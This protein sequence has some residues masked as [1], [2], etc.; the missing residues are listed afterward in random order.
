MSARFNTCLCGIS[1]VAAGLIA[2]AAGPAVGEEPLLKDPSPTL[3]TDNR[4]ADEARQLLK[5][6]AAGRPGAPAKRSPAGKF[7]TTLDP[8]LID[9]DSTPT[10]SSKL[11]VEKSSSDVKVGKDEKPDSLTPIPEAGNAGPVEIE[12]TSFHGV[13]PGVS[14]QEEVEKAWGKP[15]EV[16]KQDGL[17]MYLFSVKPFSHIE[18]NYLANKV[19]SVIIRFEHGFPS[20]TVAQQ[21]DLLKVQPVL[22]SNELGEILGQSYP[23]RGVLFSFEPGP[24]PSKTLKRVT[25]IILEPIT[26]DPFILRAE[27]NLDN[28][29]EF[30]LHDL[31]AA[32]KLQPANARSHWLRS[33]VLTLLGQHEKAMA[34][35]GEAVRLDPKEA[36]YMV[37]RALTMAQAGHVVEAIPE[38]QKAV[39]LG[40]SR[41]HVK[42][43]ALCLL[44]DLT[45]STAPPDFKLAF[46]YHMQAIQVADPLTTSRH[47][48][49]R[50]AAKELLVD[51]HLG[52][53]HDIAWGEWREKE[54]AVENWI[55]KASVLADDL[56]KNEGTGPEH[57]FRIGTR[58]L[59]ACV[60]IQGR[61]DPAFWTSETIRAGDNLIAATPD[62][63]RKSQLQWE[64]AMS[65]YDAL[66]VYQ[67]RSDRQS[68]LKYGELAISYLE[69][70]GRQNQSATTSYLLG[71]LYFRMGAVYAV[72]EGNHL[73]AVKWFDKAVPL[74]GKSPP[75]D[76]QAS[77]GRLGETFVSMGVSYW[78]TG[79]RE[80]AL[81]LTQHGADLIEDAVK[82][83]TSKST[84]LTIPYANLASMHRQLGHIDKADRL[85]EMAAKSKT[86]K[87]R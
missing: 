16:R 9:P 57:H 42:A 72:R 60:G 15:K 63:A 40:Q 25:H 14:T 65:L 30:S 32:L 71:R 18:V 74:L 64:M 69:K 36:R 1:L 73:G 3:A 47:P 80:K 78:E 29:P 26:A 19:A 48:A 67:M 22:V 86:T 4:P 51:A 54:R 27:T 50:V 10:G 84:E 34:A 23:E 82:R 13:T 59:A 77:L 85:E 33:R 28:R 20:E 55:K 52:A 66:Q 56:V 31:D 24:S 12:I 49:I 41:P 8:S 35:A 83:G 70:S 62:T 17:T 6:D 7:R 38:A 79:Q 46:Q 68:A 76:A 87:M 43:R 2:L 58:A 5:E 21:L 37:T 75:P 39:E 45:A 81:A 44:G 53:A 61:L 11:V